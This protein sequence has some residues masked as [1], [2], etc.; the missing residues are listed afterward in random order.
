MIWPPY[1]DKDPNTGAIKGLAADIGD[2]IASLLDL[3]IEYVEIV[4]GQ[5]VEELRRGR[6][7]AVCNEGPYT[8]S[9]MKYVAY[10]KPEFYVPVFIY[11]RADDT[12]FGRLDDFNKKDITFSGMDADLSQDL[13]R[14]NLP[15]AAIK[16]LPS[17]SDPAQIMLDVV[18]KKADATIIDPPSVA[19]FNK[20]NPGALKTFGA[21]PFTVYPVGFSVIAGEQDL[22]NILNAGVDAL[23]NTH[24]AERLLKKHD[25]KGEIYYPVVKPYEVR[26]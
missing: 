22:L 19:N 21:E 14:R 16:S 7:D 18:T 24:A 20:T 5:Q 9:A 1:W 2:T 26:R 12:R 6:I 3:K 13:V 25:P 10:S 17:T 4:V 11:T 23:W 15:D 8:F